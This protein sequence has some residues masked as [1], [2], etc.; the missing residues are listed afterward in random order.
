MGRLRNVAKIVFD[1]VIVL[2]FPGKTL[3]VVI[4]VLAD[5]GFLMNLLIQKPHMVGPT[6]NLYMM[7][8]MACTLTMYCGLVLV[9]VPETGE[10]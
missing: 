7:A 6:R 9:S 3:Q 8:N 1:G 4:V 10:K 5:L 2:I